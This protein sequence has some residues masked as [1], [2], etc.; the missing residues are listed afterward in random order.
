MGGVMQFEM[1]RMTDYSDGALIDEI[2]RVAAL[3][4]SPKLSRTE[5]RR[6]SRVHP[7]TVERRFGGWQ[8]ARL[9]GGWMAPE[10][11]FKVDDQVRTT[12]EYSEMRANPTLDSKLFDPQYW[13]SVHWRE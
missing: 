8:Q 13:T 6:R 10:V 9:G 3:V 7:T 1:R 4:N 12:E 2:K 11:I 5:F